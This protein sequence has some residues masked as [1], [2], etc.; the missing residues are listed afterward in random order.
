MGT[1]KEA[2]SVVNK[3]ADNVINRGA[4]NDIIKSADKIINSV[5]KSAI[6]N[7]VE[8]K[9]L[10]IAFPLKQGMVKAV[11]G[12]DFSLERGA[13]TALVGES[14]SGKTTLASALLRIVSNPGIITEG[15]VL[16][17]GRDILKFDAEELRKYKWTETAMVF[18]A[19]QNALNPL[20]TVEAQML[21][22]FHV[23]KYPKSDAEALKRAEYLLESVR[24]D[25]KRVLNCYPHELSGG[26]KQRVMIAFALLLDPK[27]LILDEPT[28]ALDVITQDYIFDILLK[29]YKE[30]KLTMLL[31]THDIAVVARFAQK[32]SVMYA[33]H[34]VEGGDI[35]SMFREPLHPY[36]GQLLRAAP[37]LTDDLRE[38]ETIAGAPPDLMNAPPGCAF[39]PR[40]AQKSA[41]CA[42][43]P[44][45]VTILPGGRTI[46]CHLY[47]GGGEKFGRQEPNAANGP[48]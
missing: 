2:D 22:T 30:L 34:I 28:T 37:S 17:N 35:K 4:D 14:G 7:I 23:H 42:L 36:T 16:Y 6:D 47:G 27:F 40:C 45:G 46:Q 10:T 43:T 48:E 8:I 39:E 21:E 32:M 5:A 24:L 33:G 41:K 12:V 11:N 29:I 19:A 20:M 13:I 44:P 18:Q 9:N 15:E 31:M 26:M 38:R 1:K 3:G 25:A